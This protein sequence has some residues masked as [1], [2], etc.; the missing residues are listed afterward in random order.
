MKDYRDEY[1]NVLRFATNFVEQTGDKETKDKTLDRINGSLDRMK[2]FCTFGIFL[3]YYGISTIL[4]SSVCLGINIYFENYGWAMAWFLLVSFS[5]WMI[6]LVH[7]EI[8]KD[9]QYILEI[10]R[11]KEK[12]ENAGSCDR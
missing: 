3:Q 5:M 7:N 10:I 1:L 11:L 4:L 12:M 8:K 2:N 6:N 9:R